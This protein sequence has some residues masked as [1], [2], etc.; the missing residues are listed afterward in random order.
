VGSST[1]TSEWHDVHDRPAGAC[2]TRFGTGQVLQHADELR[3]A[4]VTGDCRG[5]SRHRGVRFARAHP[6]RHSVSTSCADMAC[7]ALRI[8]IAHLEAEAVLYLLTSVETV[9]APTS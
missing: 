2:R 4:R 6:T 5:R 3:R 7:A 8:A 9:R 1:S